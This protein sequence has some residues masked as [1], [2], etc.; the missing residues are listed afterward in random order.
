[1]QAKS[2]DWNKFPLLIGC[3]VWRSTGWIG[4]IYHSS[5]DQRRSLESYSQCFGTVEGNST[6]YSIPPLNWTSSWS[7]QAADGFKFCFK[8][9]RKI[10][11]DERLR[12]SE[13]TLKEFV[14]S[15]EPLRIADK[16]G[17]T[18]LQMGPNFSSLEWGSLESFL[19]TLP[20]NIRWA[21]ELRHIDYFDE[22]PHRQRIDGLLKELGFAR[23]LFD[24]SYLHSIHA[25]TPTERESQKRKPKV[26]F[27]SSVTSENPM[28][29]LV[30]SDIVVP[31][32]TEKILQHWNVWIDHVARWLD[33]GLRPFIFVHTPNDQ[34]APELARALYTR[35]QQRVQELGIAPL[36]DLP[37]F[38]SQREPSR[39][40]EKQTMFNFDD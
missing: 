14:H 36:P 4:T 29:R 3:P 20:D 7:A 24:A 1:M 30:G 15:L 8:V 23:V 25:R 27:L 13:Q 12:N 21:V 11:H 33:E 10:S 18:F 37:K 16:L 38:E 19:Q 40:S 26:P 2:L 17:P 34:Y 9:P 22:N 31:E 28:V 5:A 35:I 32:D 6:F 39:V